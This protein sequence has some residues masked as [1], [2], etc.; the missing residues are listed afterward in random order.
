MQDLRPL[1]YSALADLVH[2]VR[3]SLTMGQLRR[4]VHMYSRNVHD[5]TLPA[6]IQTTSVRLL[7]NLTDFIF[8]NSEAD[9]R[10]GKLLLLRVL[11]TLVLKFDSLQT[12]AERCDPNERDGGRLRRGRLAGL[13]PLRGCVDATWPDLRASAA[14]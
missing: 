5:P 7:L 3:S 6:T 13:P 9:P 11:R 10:A 8:H 2:H 14:A 4:V 1:A 12:Y